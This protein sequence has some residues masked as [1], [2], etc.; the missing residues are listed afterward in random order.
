MVAK[1][2][3]S[4]QTVSGALCQRTQFHVTT[5]SLS[6]TIQVSTSK[7]LWPNRTFKLLLTVTKLLIMQ[8]NKHQAR[9]LQTYAKSGNRAR[10]HNTRILCPR[11]TILQAVPAT[12]RFSTTSRATTRSDDAEADPGNQNL[13]RCERCSCNVLHRRPT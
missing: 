1:I 10:R 12:Y 9:R 3:R 4:A 11:T 8:V 6:Q 13:E 2:S 7:M 5:Y